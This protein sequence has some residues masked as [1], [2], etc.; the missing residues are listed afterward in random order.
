MA[1]LTR[2]KQCQ[3]AEQ[4]VWLQQL[5]LLAPSSSGTAACAAQLHKWLII[6]LDQ[7]HGLQ[8]REC[9]RTVRFRA[10]GTGSDSFRSVSLLLLSLLLP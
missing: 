4:H 2:E 6:I 3:R 5:P 1:G 10:V 8:W 9:A 7:V